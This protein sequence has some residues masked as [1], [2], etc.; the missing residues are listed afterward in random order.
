MQAE[1]P[2]SVADQGQSSFVRML[3][4][5]A[6]KSVIWCI[7]AFIITYFWPS[8]SWVWY[9][10]I[11]FIGI[12]LLAALLGKAVALRAQQQARRDD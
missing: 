11:A 6:L 9:V 4:K 7:L 10:V 3:V 12:G 2:Q 1:E 8:A 5:T